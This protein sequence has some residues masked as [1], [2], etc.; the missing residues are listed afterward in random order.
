MDDTTLSAPVVAAERPAPVSRIP[1]QSVLMVVGTL[2]LTVALAFVPSDVVARL[3]NYGYLGV[4]LLTLLSSA[5]IV[6]PAPAIGVA[7]LAGTTLNPWLVGV[8]AG[9][10]AALGETTGYVAGFGGSSFASQSRFYPRIERWVQRWGIPTLFTLAVIP[11][12]FF[13]LAGIAAGT[14]RIPF[15]RFLLACMAGKTLR[16][17]GVAW[18][19]YLLSTN[20]VL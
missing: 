1:W 7:L 12:P 20:G 4:F 14:M 16:F 9:V 8:V 2:A 6:L 5:T 18:V 17:I 13:D 3:G 15:R 19:G 10:A 11:G